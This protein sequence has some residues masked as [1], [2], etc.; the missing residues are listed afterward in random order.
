MQLGLKLLLFFVLFSGAWWYWY[1]SS[2]TLKRMGD[3]PLYLPIGTM[4]VFLVGI[5]YILTYVGRPSVIPD[6]DPTE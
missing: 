2:E 4:F 1:D 5:F 6:F 3:Y